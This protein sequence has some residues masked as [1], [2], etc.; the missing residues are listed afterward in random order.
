[1]S[2][3][4]MRALA[5]AA[6]LAV[7]ILEHL[8]SSAPRPSPAPAERICSPGPERQAL[9]QQPGSLHAY[10]DDGCR[11][12]RRRPRGR[13][14]HLGCEHG[15]GLRRTRR[16]SAGGARVIEGTLGPDAR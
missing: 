13:F 3:T 11:Q 1:M 15:D 7:L 4:G 14:G 10:G 6:N 8:E 2:P 9:L 5:V 16:L 12:H